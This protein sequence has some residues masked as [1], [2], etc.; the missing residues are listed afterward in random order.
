MSTT[1]TLRTE[2]LVHLAWPIFV[3]HMTHTVVLLVDLWFFSHLGDQVAATVGQLMPVIWLGAFVIPVFAGTGVSVASQFMGAQQHHRVVPAYMMNL[4][5]TATM[6]LLFA[7]ILF[8]F[9]GAIGRTMGLNAEH[10]VV[11]A[12]YLGAMSFY[13]VPMGVLVAYNAVLSSRGLTHWLMYTSFV[14][15]SLNL[16][17]ASLFVL[18]FGWGVRGVVA[19]SVISVSTATIIALWLVHGRL[20]V[21]FYLKGAWRDMRSVIPPMMRIGVSNAFEPFSYSIQQI[22]LSSMIIKLGDTA[23]AANTYAG[24]AQMFQIT[25]SLSLALGAQILMGHWMGARRFEDVNRLY[26]RV[27]RWGMAVAG[28]YAGALWVFSDHVFAIFTRDPE[29]KAVGASLLFVAVCFESARAVNIIG[30]FSLKTVGDAR[31]PLIIA[32][33]FIWGILPVILAIDHFWSLTI[34]GFWICFATDEIIRAGLNLWRWRTGKWKSMGIAHS[35]EG[36]RAIP[37]AEALAAET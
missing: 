22:I 29:I 3:Q 32:I 2:S 7:A 18:G 4:L 33:V 34:V 27:I 31:F 28:F 23:M 16:A 6:A 30:G 10:N 25:F 9:G 11:G 17:L 8:G 37:P 15:A 24:R 14:I 36:T 1:S 26:W 35:A 20:R 12:T 5:C 19:A 13:F 21:K